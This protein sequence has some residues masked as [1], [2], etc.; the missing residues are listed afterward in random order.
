MQ[1]IDVHTHL[2]PPEI[3]AKRGDYLHRDKYFCLLYEN[4]HARMVEVE[5]LLTSMDKTGIAKSVIFGFAFADLGLCHV[6]NDWLLDVADLYPN[7]LIPF[8][9]V[10]PRAGKDALLEAR[11]CL[12]AGARGIGELMPGAQGFELTDFALLDPLMDLARQCRVPL[13]VH[14]NELVG[15][16]YPGKSAQ[17]P[18][19]AYQMAKRYP[20]NVIIFAHWGGGL[21]FYE[22]M[23]EVRAELRNVYY[24]TAASLY[25]YEDALFRHAMAWTP[26]KILFGTDYPLITQE[27]FLQ[28]VRGAGLDAEALVQFLGGNASAVL[29]ECVD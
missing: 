20:E 24:D 6:C 13:N 15:H 16:T 12:E 1:V 21:L 10:N 5:E 19:Q 11:R 22:R 7:R 27:H 29:G 9:L 28:R 23:P 17:G 2:F 25:L 18:V 3:A 14:V 8:A 26:D 4:P